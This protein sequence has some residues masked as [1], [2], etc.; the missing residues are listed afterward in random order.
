LEGHDYPLTGQSG[1]H[2][3][4]NGRVQLQEREIRCWLRTPPFFPKNRDLTQVTKYELKEVRA[5]LN[6]RPRKTLGYRTP[7]KVFFG[8]TTSLTVALTS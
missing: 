5:T 6:P 1:V 7:H 8:T 3:G 4:L 2:A